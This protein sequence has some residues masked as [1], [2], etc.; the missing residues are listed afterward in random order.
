MTEQTAKLYS[1]IESKSNKVIAIIGLSKNAG[2]TSVLN[3]ILTHCKGF[4]YGVLST[5]RDGEE[6]DTVYATPKPAVHLPPNCLFCC[7]TSSLDAHGS[8][9]RIIQK[10]P[11]KAG[12]RQ[13]WL[14]ESTSAIDTEIFGPSNVGAQTECIRLMQQHGAKKI[15]VDGSIDRKSIV[16]SSIVNSSFL[17]AGASYGS[18][19]KIMEELRRLQRL[20]HIPLTS[21]PPSIA[22]QSKESILYKSKGRW[23]DTGARSLIGHE[24]LVLDLLQQNVAQI[25]I[26]GAFTSSSYGKLARAIDSSDTVIVIRHPHVLQLDGGTVERF[27]RIYKLRTL[28]PLIISLIALNTSAVG[29]E[30]LDAERMRVEVKQE[31]SGYLVMDIMEGYD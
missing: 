23:M 3:W 11:W 12:N 22:M 28:N 19:A 4:D 13:L 30:P 29:A 5:G 24:S 7:D 14:A 9:I 16:L 26:P 18:L 10:L 1:L 17:V 25:Y 2:K 15:L 8:A 20:C 31:F 27:L 21:S 6:R